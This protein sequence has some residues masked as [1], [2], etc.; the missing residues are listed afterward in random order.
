MQLPIKL[1][2]ESPGEYIAINAMDVNANG[3]FLSVTSFRASQGV[4]WLPV[5]LFLL[6]CCWLMSCLFF[7][8]LIWFE[9]NFIL[10][11]S[12]KQQLSSFLSFFFFFFFWTGSHLVPFLL[13]LWWWPSFC[14]AFIPIAQQS[15]L[16]KRL[17]L[18]SRTQP[19]SHIRCDAPFWEEWRTYVI[20]FVSIA[21]VSV[22]MWTHCSGCNAF[23]ISASHW[24]LLSLCIEM[25]PQTYNKPWPLSFAF[26]GVFVLSGFS[27]PLV[28]RHWKFFC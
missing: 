26:S 25:H 8:F 10:E 11:Q 15:V 21:C 6:L 1:T 13:L 2:V 4:L 17:L 9:G 18:N 20:F 7:L 19:N 14:K 5:C 22:F 16:E 24:I 23:L 12:D 27:L 28:V 3:K